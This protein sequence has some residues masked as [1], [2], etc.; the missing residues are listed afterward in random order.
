MGMAWL[1][2]AVVVACAWAGL[3]AAP[4]LAPAGARWWLAAA[5]AG[6]GGLVL[7]L[8]RR[9]RAIA[10]EGLLLGAAGGTAGL[11]AGLALG[12]AIDALVPGLGGIGRGAVALGMG[13]LGLAGALARRDALAGLSARL[14]SGAPTPAGDGAGRAGGDVVVIL[15][16]SVIIDGRIVEVCE[17]GFLAGPLVVPQFVLRELQQIADSPDAVRRN[18][19]KRGFDVLRRLQGLPGAPVRLDDRDVPGVE[20]LTDRRDAEVAGS[21]GDERA[22][23]AGF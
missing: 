11:V 23:R 5:G 7:L 8:E 20:K 10:L 18:R 17:A 16:T 15:D 1:R 12:T 9:A 19:G 2:L 21:P 13:Y 22:G 14:R 4:A 3:A 6:V